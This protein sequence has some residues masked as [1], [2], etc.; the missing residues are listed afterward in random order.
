MKSDSYAYRHSVIIVN[1]P[2]SFI[3]MINTCMR[4]VKQR[5]TG[6]HWQLYSLHIRPVLSSQ[7]RNLRQTGPQGQNNWRR[8]SQLTTNCR[9]VDKR[10]G[11]HTYILILIDT[12]YQLQPNCSPTPD[13]MLQSKPVV[14]R[15]SQNITTVWA[16]CQPFVSIE[17][18]NFYNIKSSFIKNI[19]GKVVWV[20]IAYPL[21]NTI[22]ILLESKRLISA[23]HCR[24]HRMSDCIRMSRLS[25]TT[26]VFV[27]QPL[28]CQWLQLLFTF[29]HQKYNVWDKKWFMF[30]VSFFVKIHFFWKMYLTNSVLILISF[31]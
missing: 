2:T 4:C 6:E 22:S 7:A 9:R 12:D 14:R 23:D 24:R 29:K 26:I 30:F 17:N 5:V 28:D 21:I 8:E 10:L 27:A 11:F 15:K 3:V 18:Y 13:I 25:D 31:N 19:N 16:L 1:Y 20:F